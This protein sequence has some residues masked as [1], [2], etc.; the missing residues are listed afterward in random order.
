MRTPL[1]SLEGVRTWINGDPLQGSLAGRPV[2]VQFWSISCHLCHESADRA[3]A[4]RAK[5]EPQGV[6]FLAV[7]QPRSEAELD[8]GAV[9]EDALNEMH[10]TQPCAVDNDHVLVERFANQF[11][12][13]FYVFDREHQLRHFQAGDKGYERIEAAIERVVQEPAQAQV[14]G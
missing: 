8:T 12:P 5:Y 4:W 14:P 7:H 13:S 6:A 3:N 11:V 1:P 10:L 2:V 9:R